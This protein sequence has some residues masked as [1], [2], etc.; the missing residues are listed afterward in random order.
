MALHWIRVCCLP[1]AILFT[2]IA[3][4]NVVAQ[5]APLRPGFR[6]L[7]NDRQR[8]TF[9]AVA[10]YVA[11]NPAADDAEQAY[12][13][14]MDTA[15]TNG[16]E[17][18][19]AP[20]AEA[21]L[22]RGELDQASATA[23]RQVLCLGL[24]KSGK[25]PEAMTQFD[26][27]LRGVRFQQP[28]KTVDFAQSLATQARM[29]GE[30]AASRAIYERLS[31]AFPLNP[32]VSELAENKL[33]KLDLVGKP[34]PRIAADDLEGKR[35]DLADY[36]GKVVLVDFWATNC[37]PCLAEFP[38]LKQLYS[39]LQPRGFE[40]IGISYDESPDIVEAF[41]ARAKLPWR[42][43]MNAAPEGA[44][45]KRFQVLTIP[46]LYLIDRQGNIAQLDVHGNDLRLSIE[47]LLGN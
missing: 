32:Q 28:T 17:A 18:E 2:I 14:L 30:F 15:V 42:M 9:K 22:K 44:V 40:V 43:A 41:R 1:C 5:E 47:K 38:N 31:S 24:A 6:K 27:Y 19:A 33:A 35:I 39:E 8:E 11:K 7:L 3:S 21:F 10:D 46:A 20:V 26:A 34:A 36:A 12:L 29:A 25:L 45:G 16:L 23:A 37:P 13:W 4:V